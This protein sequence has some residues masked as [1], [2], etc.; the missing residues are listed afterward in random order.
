MSF[1][2]YMKVERV[3]NILTK[4]EGNEIRKVVKT[5][6]VKSAADLTDEQRKNLPGR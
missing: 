4:D 1:T 2:K 5:A 6:G 3:T